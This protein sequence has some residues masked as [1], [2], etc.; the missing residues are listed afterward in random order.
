MV[1][2]EP[3]LKRQKIC[4][5][6]TEDSPDNVGKN[7]DPARPVNYGRASRLLVPVVRSSVAQSRDFLSPWM[8]AML[9]ACLNLRGL[10][11]FLTFCFGLAVIVSA[12]VFN[13]LHDHG[14]EK[15]F[16]PFVRTVYELVGKSGVTMFLAT[17]GLAILLLGFAVPHPRWRR[18]TVPQLENA[19]RLPTLRL[20]RDTRRSVPEGGIE[21][22]T[23]KYLPY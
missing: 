21:L 13:V 16:P 2:S 1:L 14:T 23:R 22:Q 20:P 19:T 7:A 12:S 4:S 9:R 8:T 6:L 5:R 3:G 17:I 18:K 11:Q 10:P 15:S